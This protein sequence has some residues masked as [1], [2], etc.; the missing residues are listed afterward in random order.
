MRLRATIRPGY[1]K[2]EYVSDLAVHVLGVVSVLVAV[3]VL[4]ALAVIWRGDAVSVLAVSV[5]GLSLIAMILCS[6]LFNINRSAR[7]HGVLRRL[8]H[9]AIYIKIAGTYTPFVLLT[10]GQ[11]IVLLAGLWS[12]ALAGSG[13]KLIDPARFRWLA[14]ALYLGMGWVG[15]LAGWSLFAQM[16]APV[17]ALVVAG[18]L[19]YTAGVAFYLIE[20]MR[21]HTTIWHIFVLI[22]SMMFF[23]AVTWHMADTSI[24]HMVL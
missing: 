20:H 11:A 10:G 5:Y 23:A 8:D 3:P 22:A 7:W 15:A 4:I 13:L 12:A 24:A 1:S 17:L 9:S 2:A 16:S 14:L 21:F 18:G 6:A 19:L